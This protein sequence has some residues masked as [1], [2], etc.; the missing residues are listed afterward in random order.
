MVTNRPLSSTQQL[1]YIFS[2][3]CWSV[4]NGK[5]N[6]AKASG[7]VHCAFNARTG[8]RLLDIN[9]DPV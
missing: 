7:G 5:F 6:Y 2:G 8:E 4:K 9:S 3:F 1:P